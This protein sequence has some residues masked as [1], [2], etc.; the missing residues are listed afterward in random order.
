MDKKAF[1]M[2]MIEKCASEN[3]APKK[4]SFAKR[5]GYSILGGV[6]GNHVGGM[7]G[8]MASLPI[9]NA[10]NLKIQE[11][12]M[13]SFSS[14]APVNIRPSRATL[15]AMYG[16]PAAGAVAGGIYGARLGKKYKQKRDALK[17]N[18]ITEE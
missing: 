8:G 18:E 7:L 13:N 10:S 12:M 15:A 9:A 3:E 4:E 14:G 16:L 2:D 11:Q 1:Y 6:A 5:H 17:N